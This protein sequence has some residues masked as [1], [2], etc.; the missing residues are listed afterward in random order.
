MNSLFGI[1][2]NLSVVV[3]ACTLL[4]FA[5]KYAWQAYITWRTHTGSQPWIETKGKVLSASVQSRVRPGEDEMLYFLM[6]SYQYLV[7]GE[8]LMGN[9]VALAEDSGTSI[10][11]WAERRLNEYL[12]GG[13]IAVYY[14]PAQPTEAVL[15]PVYVNNNWKNAVIALGLLLFAIAVLVI[16]A[17]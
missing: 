14:N 15:H 12:E 5:V 6:V 17:S 4:G 13:E 9:R 11:A 3:F 16:F 10:Q 2:R 7:N 8:W 1:V